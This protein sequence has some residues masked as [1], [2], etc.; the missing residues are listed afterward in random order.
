M[1]IDMNN[2]R[3]INK[4][5]KSFIGIF[6]LVVVFMLA[7]IVIVAIE[8]VADRPSD[9]AL[10][11]GSVVYNNANTPIELSADGILTQEISSG[12]YYLNLEDGQK[13]PLGK[14][15]IAYS[16]EGVKVFGG[17]YLIDSAG[18][19][20][21]VEDENTFS[22]YQNPH[23]IKLADRKYVMVGATIQDEEQV[24]SVQN[25][26]YIV[27]DTVGNAY[28]MSSNMGLKTTSPTVVTSGDISFDI[29]MEELSVAG[30]IINMKTIMGSTN[31][32]D[33]AI[34]KELYDEQTPDSIELT[35]KGG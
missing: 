33:T 30:Q 17:G 15:T 9:I 21:V 32:Y 18:A 19:V 16:S 26:L 10:T 27:L 28:L 20:T 25:Y 22:D 29:A 3:K 23:L 24:F 6:S 31:T 14:N 11:A 13:I 1:V 34:N 2:V 7:T 8:A 5:A 12:Q 35:I 4:T